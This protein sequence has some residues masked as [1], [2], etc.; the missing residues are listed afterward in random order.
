MLR[1]FTTTT[2]HNRIARLCISTLKRTISSKVIGIDLGTTNSAVAYIRDANDKKSAVIIESDQGQRTTPSIV[3][4][5][6]NSSNK[7][8]TG[9]EYEYSSIVGTLAKRQA[10]INPENT[11]FA[12]KR[13][14]GRSFNDEEVQRD[15]KLMPYKICN[16][17]GK[18]YLKLSN[19]NE[20]KSPSEIASIL[21]KYL[22]NCSESYLNEPID[23]AVI[24]VP[25]YF[26]DSQRQATKDAGKLAGLKV[27]RVVNEPTAA[28]LSFGMDDIKKNS[29]IIAVY[30]LGG[31]T[32]DISIL[33][34]EDGVF[35]VRATNGDTHLGGED[36]DAIIVNHLLDQFIKSNSELDR[37]LICANRE[38]M[39][40]LREAAEKCKIELS[41]VHETTIK[42]PFL[43]DDKHLNITLKESELDGMTL[44][45]INKTIEPV[46]RALKDSDIEPDDVDD[47]ILVGGMT[48]MPKIR[49]T[50]E[51]LFG[52]KPNITV[53]PDETVALGAAIQGGI[54][55]GEI[56]NVLLLDVTPLTLGIE[57]FGG[58]F[59]PLIPRNTT[60]PVTKTEV[61]ST[62]VDGQT[63][64]DIKVY[65]GE[66]GLVR[67][68]K[69]I[70][71]FKLTG[72]P[73][74]LKGI[75]QIFVTFDIDADG[76]ID[77]SASEKSSG[78]E[79]SITVVPKSGLT[80]DEI[81]KLIE[82]ANANRSNDNLIR[83]RLE[84]IT[85]ADIMISDTELSFAKYKGLISKDDQYE[86]IVNE[87]KELRF[88]INKFK[89]NENDLSIDVNIIKKSTDSLQNKAFKL[90]ER[91]TK[92]QAAADQ[93]E[94]KK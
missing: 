33:D 45:L 24:T 91:V 28:A 32:F 25:A 87:L 68:N 85:K 7:T 51:N 78:K 9:D 27:L 20:V 22:K 6:R 43:Y 64:V 2:N 19:S 41:H 23:K 39:Q 74:M 36:F 48:R 3:A 17:D 71:D 55:S 46:K 82:E 69:L 38:I 81:N 5:S 15:I 84:L 76:I 54:L 93:K 35:E 90:F 92:A 60:V 37:E 14:I 44:H 83:Q 56:K 49:K 13:L 4:F 61:F 1:R 57:T 31:G 21:L 79:Q 66:R 72:I 75:P 18:A 88:M 52:K 70:G 50:V 11:F 80:E 53:N 29:G 16:V 40:R 34:I 63:G 10:I 47:V 58:A 30:D 8:S 86:S 12:T 65:Q 77:V 94:S 42:L 89:E 67:D 73:P 59:A 26:N 62:G